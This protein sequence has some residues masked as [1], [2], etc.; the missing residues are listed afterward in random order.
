MDILKQIVYPAIEEFNLSLPPAKKLTKSPNTPLFGTGATIDSVQL[1][2]LVIET[3]EQL[4]DLLDEEI[5]LVTEEA[6]SRKESPFRDIAGLT[7]YIE[8]IV[9]SLPTNA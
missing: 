6:M 1:V 2:A 7:K 4:Q 3:E 9:A 8:N 5:T